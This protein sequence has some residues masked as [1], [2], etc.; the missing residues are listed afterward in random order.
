MKIKKILANIMCA[1]LI[2]SNLTVVSASNVIINE[3]PIDDEGIAAVSD[4]SSNETGWTTDDSNLSD[5]EVTYTQ[6]S[7]YFVT[8]PKTITLDSKKQ[9]TY[10]IKVTG[11]IDTNQRVYV[12]PVD[13]ISNTENIDFY[14][15]DQNSKKDDVVATVKQNK[16]YWDSEEVELGYEETDNSISAPDLTSGTWK[17]TFQVEIKLQSEASHKHNFIDGKCECGEIDPNHTHNYVDGTCDICGKVDPNHTHN[18]VDGTCT[19]CG[20][21]EHVHNYVDGRCEFWAV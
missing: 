11:D 18:Y 1:S 21:E 5:V 12:A 19:I 14:M 17:G 20:D 16:L 3:S 2:L 13:A 15:K 4:T 6:S 9:A 10:S 8:I 7:S